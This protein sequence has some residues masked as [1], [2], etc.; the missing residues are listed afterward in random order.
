MILL[1]T[2][3]PKLPS[4]YLSGLG[5]RDGDRV[6]VFC[7]V[8]ASAFNYSSDFEMLEGTSGVNSIK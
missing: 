2:V 3:D 8:T 6:N 1:G 4:H 5:I 7:S